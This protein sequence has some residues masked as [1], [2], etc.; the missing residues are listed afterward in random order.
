MM[1]PTA[2]FGMLF[3]SDYFEDYIGELILA[4]MTSVETEEKSDDPEVQKR[5]IQK[6]LKVS[7]FHHFILLLTCW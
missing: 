5:N 1:D 3:G 6:K 2:V 7:S 4:S